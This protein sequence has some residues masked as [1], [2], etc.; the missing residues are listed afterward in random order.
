MTGAPSPTESAAEVHRKAVL[1]VNPTLD[2]LNDAF[3]TFSHV[4]KARPSVTTRFLVEDLRELLISFV[5]TMTM[6]VN[7]GNV[8]GLV[9]HLQDAERM[10]QVVAQ[11][12]D[13]V[14]FQHERRG[15]RTE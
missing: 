13:L 9:D 14:R 5:T 15:F 3:A 1:Q 2:A 10:T 6:Q 7:T 11:F 4:V 8:N 12:T